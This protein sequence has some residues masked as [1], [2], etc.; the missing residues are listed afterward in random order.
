MKR[1]TE[2]SDTA[3]PPAE[4]TDYRLWARSRGLE[5]YGVP[6][7]LVS[8][9]A[10]V[11]RWKAWERERAQWAEAHGMDEMDLPTSGCGAPFDWDA[12]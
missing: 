9:R 6:D 12:I 10:P 1:R 5:P 8:M 2:E 7:D 3:V 4:L 11:A